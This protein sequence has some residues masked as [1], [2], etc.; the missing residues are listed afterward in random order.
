MSSDALLAGG[1]AFNWAPGTR[2]E[3]SNLGYAILGRVVTA[4]SGVPYDEFIR[5]RLLA[6]LGMSGPGSPRRSSPPPSSRRRL[7]ARSGRLA[8]SCRSTRT[9]RSRRWAACSPAS[10]TS[11]PGA[12]GSRR[13]SRRTVRPADSRGRVPPHPLAAASRR[14]MQLPQAV[15]GWRAPDRIPGG[16]PA[17]PAYY[18]FGLFVD[19]DPAFGRVVSHSGGYPGFG[20]NMRWHPATGLAVIALGNG[21]YSPMHS[22]GRPGAQG[23]AHPLAAYHVALAPPGRPGCGA[24]AGRAVAADPGG[25]RRGEPLLRTGT[26]RRPT[27]CSP[28]TWPSTG[29]TAERRAD[30]ALLRAQDR[31]VRPSTRA[32]RR[33][34]TPRRSAAGG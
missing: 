28:R 5:T 10:P 8:A 18:G 16:P 20:S 19:E 13:R 17:A 27:R 32:S 4:A 9:A 11:R 2:F 29:P 15:T 31:R 14:Q 26:T 25:G 24:A 33:S 22:P 6:P 34:R 12:P 7:P 23:A 1:V 30:L 3:Y 21:T